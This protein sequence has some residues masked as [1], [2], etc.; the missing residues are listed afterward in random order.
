MLIFRTT[1]IGLLITSFAYAKSGGTANTTPVKKSCAKIVETQQKAFEKADWILEGSVQIIFLP[2]NNDGIELVLERI[3]AIRKWDGFQ[4]HAIESAAIAPCFPGGSEIFK[5]KA[6]NRLIGKRVR[7]FGN[8]HAVSPKLRFFF[9]EEIEENGS[10]TLNFSKSKQVSLTSKIH[11]ENA[12]NPLDDGW[13]RANSTDGDFSVDLPGLFLD[14]TKVENGSTAFMLRSTD[15]QGTTFM[16]VFERSSPMSDMAGSFDKET[17]KPNAK[18]SQFEGFPTVELIYKSSQGM[19]EEMTT[20][21]RMIRVPGGTF[22]LAIATP[23]NM[24]VETLKKKDRFFSSLK[25]H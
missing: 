12:Q 18:L 2:N 13:H 9:M 6:A 7:L 16:V 19:A 17:Q 4:I 5:G 23:K 1:L 21:G 14:V 15:K 20:F 3:E 22:M 25:I 11:R 8:K 24:V 10:P